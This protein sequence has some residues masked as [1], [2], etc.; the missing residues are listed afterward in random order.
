MKFFTKADIEDAQ[1]LSA[2]IFLSD[3][4]K[5]VLMEILTN[6]DI[7]INKELF[8]QYVNEY[9]DQRVYVDLLKRR[10]SAKYIPSDFY[11]DKVVSW[12]ITFT[13]GSLIVNVP[14]EDP[15]DRD[16]IIDLFETNG[17]EIFDES[18]E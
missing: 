2:A 17:Y 3:A 9:S 12:N 14:I 18:E 1:S 4:S 5:E 6:P 16:R 10:M 11:V 15:T 7:D 13:S 8:S